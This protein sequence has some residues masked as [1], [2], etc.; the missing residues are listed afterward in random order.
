MRDFKKL[1]DKYGSRNILV[2]SKDKIPCSCYDT[3]YNTANPDC[4]VCNGSGYLSETKAVKMRQGGVTSTGTIIKGNDTQLGN[5]NSL[6]RVFY[7]EDME[8]SEE[9]LVCECD[10]N[11]QIPVIKSV[12]N[13]NYIEHIKEGEQTTYLKLITSIS[14]CQIPKVTHY[15]GKVY[16]GVNNLVK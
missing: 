8:V 5:I 6:I 15:Q 13:I 2:H 11:G 7:L 9:D 12:Y 1:I 10:W 16:V 4:E 14:A 3:L